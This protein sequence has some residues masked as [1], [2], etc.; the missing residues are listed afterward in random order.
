MF[1]DVWAAS[2]IWAPDS[3]VEPGLPRRVVALRRSVAVADRPESVPARV[4]ANARYAL[5]VNAAEVSRGP[6][7]AS[8]RRQRYDVVDLAPFLRRGL[9]ELAVLAW[10]YGQAMPWWAPVPG[11]HPDLARGGFVLEAPGLVVTDAAWS[12]RHLEGWGM[13]E[14]AGVLGRGIE[15]IDLSELA[16]DWTT[17]AFDGWS[18]AV[19]RGP[20]APGRSERHRPPSYP[21]GPVGPRTTSA[22]LL[23][24]V[25]LV[26]APPGV[27]RGPNGLVTGTVRV[28]GDARSRRR[29]RNGSWPANL[30]RVSTT[31]ALRWSSTVSARRWISMA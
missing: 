31:R 14:P 29:W 17:A 2:W 23:V 22:P 26:E 19:P 9:N 24:E 25:A 15:R 6:V 20:F 12:A 21:I 11:V 13:T 30:A 1:P 18:S 3:D 27:W 8:A 16:S 4:H 5:W 28:E 10:C 7:R